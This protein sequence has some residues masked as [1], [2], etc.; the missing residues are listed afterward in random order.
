MF[1][2]SIACPVFISCK[3]NSTTVPHKTD[4]VFADTAKSPVQNEPVIKPKRKDGI[5]V[6]TVDDYPVP[7]KMFV[8][9]YHRRESGVLASEDAAWFSN[10][11]LNQT[12]I[13]EL[14]TDFHRL[15][16]YHFFEQ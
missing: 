2:L 9:N 16:T 5:P 4:S 12:L 1:I 13:F 7:T 10:D 6:F 11:T 14:Y 3:N 15:Y 8:G